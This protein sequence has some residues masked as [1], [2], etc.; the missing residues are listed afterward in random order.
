MR[1]RDVDGQQHV[2]VAMTGRVPTQLGPGDTVTVIHPPGAPAQVEVF[3]TFG[4]WLIPGS[5]SVLAS[6]FALAG[7][8]GLAGALRQIARRRWL[9]RH[10]EWI[11]ARDARV[12]PV[13]HEKGGPYKPFAV[14]AQW[15]DPRAGVT[16]EFRS[17]PLSWDPAGVI[18]AGATMD[19]LVDPADP[20][21]YWVGLPPTAPGG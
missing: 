1:Y 21:R 2:F 20:R 11:I 14:V 10:G 16:R 3:S 9:A 12:V 7:L 4:E 19:V 8:G 15:V 18:G 17:D 13:R 5:L 6:A